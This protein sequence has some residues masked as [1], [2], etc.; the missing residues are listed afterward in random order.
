M[1]YLKP[2]SPLEFQEN[3]IYPLTT[4]DQIILP[5]GNRWNGGIQSVEHVTTL[6]PVTNWEEEEDGS[7]TQMVYINDFDSNTV[8]PAIDVDMSKL[9]KETY[10]DAVEAWACVDKVQTIE[11]GVLLT[12]FST[13]PKV[14]FD[15]Y[16]NIN[17]IG[18]VNLPNA[19]G[20]SF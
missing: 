4:F 2:Q 13:K 9:T 10:A 19:S 14:D 17:R 3:Y 1:R 11:D 16:L 12:C 18:I 6:V 15:I 8:C 5:D 20:V 7:Y